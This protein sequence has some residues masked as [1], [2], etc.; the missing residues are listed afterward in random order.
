MKQL[1]L[2][3]TILIFQLNFAQRTETFKIKKYSVAVL[4]DSLKESS[5]LNF[6]NGK[7][8]T[9][10]DSGS[11]SELF[12][13]N[14]KSGKIQKKLV[15]KLQNED[16][17][18]LTNDG[19]NFYIGDF[20]NNLG[21]RKDLK[22][23]KIPF[24]TALKLDSI[25]IISFYYPEQKDFTPKN[26]NNDFDGEAMIYLNGKIHIFTKEWRAKLTTHYTIDPE[27]Y[28]N[29]AAK[30]IETFKTDFM[31]TD[32]A[33]FKEKL[34][35]VG[36]TKIGRVYLEVFAKSNKDTFFSEVPKKYYLG[37]A[38][39]LG[40][41]EGIAVNEGGIYFSGEYFHSPLGIKKGQLFFI[42]FSDFN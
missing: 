40:Q 26:L 38:F 22:I 10:N 23:Y 41:I 8:Y 42:P 28:A 9:F 27:N 35:L 33:Y 36:Y 5:V 4:D 13:I 31:V 32:A 12:Q 2:I 25:K 34:Y 1:L 24:D 3:F 11:T 16:W 6:F 37:S 19:E 17:E 30:K 14:P 15:T 39:S 21:S 29:Q 7:L 18:S 20:G